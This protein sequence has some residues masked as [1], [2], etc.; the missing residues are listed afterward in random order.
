MSW[1][2]PKS[3]LDSAVSGEIGIDVLR[4]TVSTRTPK[5]K[6]AVRLIDTSMPTGRDL[7]TEKKKE[8]NETSIT[9]D[10]RFH[11]PMSQNR[12]QPYNRLTL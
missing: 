7:V 10:W 11:P 8:E 3:H 2:P 1:Q 9:C 12:E 5:G 6:R 4:S